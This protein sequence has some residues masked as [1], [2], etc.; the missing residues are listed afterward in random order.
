[1]IWDNSKSTPRMIQEPSKGKRKR[2]RK[3]KGSVMLRGKPLSPSIG[4]GVGQVLHQD[5]ERLAPGVRWGVMGLL[6][7]RRLDSW[8]RVC[9]DWKATARTAH[10]NARQWGSC[11][12]RDRR[13][14][15]QLQCPSHAILET[16]TESQWRR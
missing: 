8:P 16:P 9:K 10:G 2:I 15:L 5:M 13:G 1:M 11:S 14:R 12:R 3:R 7:G 6:P 4:T